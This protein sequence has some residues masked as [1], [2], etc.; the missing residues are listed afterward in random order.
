MTW[1]K[2]RVELIHCCDYQE[3]GPIN[4]WLKI[5]IREL[6]VARSFKL[7]EMLK[8]MLTIYLYLNMLQ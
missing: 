3:N 4:S 2:L 5:H 7:R 6:V 1:C 8:Y